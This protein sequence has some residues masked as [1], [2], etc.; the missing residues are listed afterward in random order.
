M[1]VQ[2]TRYSASLWAHFDN[3]SIVLVRHELK[4]EEQ[5]G[6]LQERFQAGDKES[7][8]TNVRL[9]TEG[10]VERCLEKLQEERRRKK[11]KVG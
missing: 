2:K 7:L 5:E 8:G 6:E 3:Q 10:R 4:P 9:S 11:W 1:R